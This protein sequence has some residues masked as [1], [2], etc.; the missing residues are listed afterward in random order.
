MAS[1][2]S[3]F[4]AVILGI[5]SLAI[6]VVS[7]MISFLSAR[8]ARRQAIAAEGPSR[9]SVEVG[10]ATWEDPKRRWIRVDVII[11]NMTTESWDA[12]SATLTSP[13]RGKI[14]AAHLT[15]EYDEFGN[16][17]PTLP[18]DENR[19][20]ATTHPCCVVFPRGSGPSSPHHP[21]GDTARETFFL[22][23]LE[24][25]SAFHIEFVFRSRMDARRSERA[26]LYG[27]A[28]Q[29]TKTP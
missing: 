16:F 8:Y 9:P 28:S 20:T 7:L 2:I 17:V 27:F 19:F 10:E 12:T 29:A 22:G 24:K 13:S 23:P 1:T 26:H 4:P 5:I 21:F 25:S 18:S 11:R 3:E 6:S 15:S 14:A